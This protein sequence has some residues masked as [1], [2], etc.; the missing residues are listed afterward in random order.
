MEKKEP[1]WID[2]MV[3]LRTFNVLLLRS[4]FRLFLVSILMV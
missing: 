1:T 3:W 2:L 4:Y